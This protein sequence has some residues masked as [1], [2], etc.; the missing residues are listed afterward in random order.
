MNKT[1]SNGSA[2]LCL[3]LL[4]VSCAQSDFEAV[5]PKEEKPQK[6]IQFTEHLIMDGYTYP[7]G[8]A[9]ADLDGD[10]DLDL[11]SA[12]AETHDNLYWFKNDGSG[13]FK[14]N[15]IQEKDPER[16]ERHRIGDID[17]DG[18]PDV[19]I[20]KN[21]FGDLLWFENTGTPGDGKLWRRHIITQGKLPGAYDVELVDLDG[22]G[23]LDAAG[24]GWRLGNQFS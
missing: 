10:G 24:S 8:I 13:S 11:T 7:F 3:L 4:L 14:R 21:K 22:D 5:P 17:G 18:D 16:L 15:F 1:L 12:D 20:V 2:A 9:A 23:D 19:A 6:E